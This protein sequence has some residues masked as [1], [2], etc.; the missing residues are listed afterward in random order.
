MESQR[1]IQDWPVNQI[2]PHPQNRPAIVVAGKGK[3]SV[4]FVKPKPAKKAPKGASRP[5]RDWEAEERLWRE[6]CKRLYEAVLARDINVY[7]GLAVA[8]LLNLPFTSQP[9]DMALLSKHGDDWES[10]EKTCIRLIWDRT[11]A[12]MERDSKKSYASEYDW[13]QLVPV[14]KFLGIDVKK[15]AAEATQAVEPKK[16]KKEAP[17]EVPAGAEIPGVCGICGCIDDDCC[18]RCAAKPAERPQKTKPCQG[19]K[20]K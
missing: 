12:A 11:K 18:S 4:V 5:A 16:G 1:Q 19:R 8:I 17:V 6:K 10:L 13:D 9:K 15:I 7:Q 20:K 3:G 2:Q 14:A